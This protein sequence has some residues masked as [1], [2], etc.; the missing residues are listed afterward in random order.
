MDVVASKGSAPEAAR[1]RRTSS[2]GHCYR[3]VTGLGASPAANLRHF[4]WADVGRNG[5]N[6][7]TRFRQSSF[8]MHSKRFDRL[9]VVGK[10]SGGN[11]HNS[12]YPAS[13]TSK[14]AF[15]LSTAMLVLRVKEKSG[16]GL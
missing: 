2:T 16:I 10:L 11:K 8:R 9:T 4:R 5:R 12:K 3:S 6:A 1:P 13:T 14:T 15:G 7:K